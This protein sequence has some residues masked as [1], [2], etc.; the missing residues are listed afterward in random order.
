MLTALRD[1]PKDLL[2]FCALCFGMNATFI[3]RMLSSLPETSL[4]HSYG[5]ARAPHVLSFPV[6]H[7]TLQFPTPFLSPLPASSFRST[8]LHPSA[9]TSEPHEPPKARNLGV[10]FIPELFFPPVCPSHYYCSVSSVCTSGSLPPIQPLTAWP[11]PKPSGRHAS[12]SARRPSYSLVNTNGPLEIPTLFPWEPT[13]LLIYPKDWHLLLPHPSTT[14]LSCLP[15][16]VHHSLS[17]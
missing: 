1:G 9:L 11:Q 4:L 13:A 16:T 7:P 15:L 6:I 8:P 12:H 3:S 10:I 5:E 2:E 14:F 17:L